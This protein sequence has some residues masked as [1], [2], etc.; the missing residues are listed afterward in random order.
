MWNN[1]DE[2][3]SYINPYNFVILNKTGCIRNS[4]NEYDGNL[5]GYI[6]CILTT[7]TET[8]IPDTRPEKIK[9]EK[10]GKGDFL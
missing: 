3:E 9:S 8:M 2:S 7:K 5:T 6:E 10:L 4:K 1:I